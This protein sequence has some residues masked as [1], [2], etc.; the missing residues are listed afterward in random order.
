MDITRQYE[1]ST[2][3]PC[4]GIFYQDYYPGQERLFLKEKMVWNFQKWGESGERVAG[5]RKKELTLNWLTPRFYLAPPA[6][7]E[8]AAHGLGIRCSIR[9]SYGGTRLMFWE[10]AFNTIYQRCQCF[11]SGS[12][13]NQN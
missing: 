9:L 5:V 12:H 11:N 7:L 6:R 4:P 13:E 10:D 3:A 1:K 8:R 2:A